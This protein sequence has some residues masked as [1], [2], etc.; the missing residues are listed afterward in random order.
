MPVHIH[1]CCI[2]FQSS[3]QSLRYYIINQKLKIKQFYVWG[4]WT[5]WSW[6]PVGKVHS[7]AD[8]LVGAN[9]WQWEW[10]PCLL[11]RH[12]EPMYQSPCWYWGSQEGV[13]VPS[14]STC[15]SIVVW[16]TREPRG[17]AVQD[18]LNQVSKDSKGVHSG[19]KGW[20]VY[21][22][23]PA[24]QHRSGLWR[25]VRTGKSLDFILKAVGTLWMVFRAKWLDII[26]V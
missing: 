25:Q 13:S 20:K 22:A 5:N 21:A 11:R 4:I 1:L 2:S 24:G 9:S 8:Y 17:A 19:C 10:F 26:G 14:R 7:Q 6:L 3:S 18:S 12:W 15:V 23:R 16:D